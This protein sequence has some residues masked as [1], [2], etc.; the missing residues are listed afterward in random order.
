MK[1]EKEVRKAEFKKAVIKQLK[2]MIAPL[3]IL[4]IIAI[5]IIVVLFWKKEP[6]AE[7]FI[8]VR[9][10]EDGKS[11][12]V[13]E[14]DQLKLVMDGETTQFD[15]TVKSSG[16]VW[17][18]VPEGVDNDA[19]ALTLE[20]EKLKS[21]LLLTYST[22]NG[23]D[24]LYQNSTYSMERKTYQIDES[25]NAL[26]IHYTVGELEKEYIVPPIIS[27]ERMNAYLEKMDKNQQMMVKE[28]YKK[29]DI[30]NLGKKDNKEELLE[31]YPMLENEICYIIKPTVKGNIRTK[32]EQYFE[33]AGYTKQDYVEDKK[34]DLTQS[35]SNKPVFNLDMIYRLEGG[36]LVVEIPL[37][38][39]EYKKDYPVIKLCMLPYFGAGGV[40]D[41]GYILVPEGGGAII[42]F[43]NGNTAQNGYYANVYGW[44]DAIDRA[45]VVH[46]THTSFNVFGIAQGK[47]S[48]LCILEEGAPRASIQA[49][50]SGKLSSYNFA[51]VTHD[52]L[53]R[54]QYEVQDRYTGKMF[55]YEKELPDEMIRNRYRFVDSGDYVKMAES[56]HDYLAERTEGGL[57]LQQETV[58]PAVIEILCAADKV[59]QVMGVPVNRPLKLTTF[60]EA[61]S[62]LD[63]LNQNGIQNM[64]VKLT[65]WMNGGVN[66]KI[67]TDTKLVSALGSRKDL[68]DLISFAEG[69]GMDFYLDGNVSYA[70]DSKTSDGFM[71]FRDAARFVSDEKAELLPY[72]TITY[73]KKK[74]E[75]A[76]YLLRESVIKKAFR[77]LTKTAESYQANVS[78]QDIGMN[79]SSDFREDEPVS[80][81]QALED[82]VSLIKEL[83]SSGKKLMTN[84]GNDYAA[85]YSDLITNMEFSGARY[86]IINREVP[87]Y[88][89]AL[90]GYV[91]YTGESIN[92]AQDYEE[93]VLRC[94]EYG[95]G[96][97]FTV[98]Q[99]ASS[100][101]QN[102]YYSKYFG[103]DYEGWKDRIVEI[104]QRYNREL[105]HTFSQRMVN[106]IQINDKLMCTVYE[107]GTK[108]YVNYSYTDTEADGR[109]IPARDYAVVR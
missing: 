1:K 11:E 44:D 21:T 17:H 41:E 99:E 64:S 105:G 80:R 101:L 68:K 24:T 37:K 39:L 18:S 107:D 77:N 78:L 40:T 60:K 25:E 7:Q 43:N 14:N 58:A 32:M 109:T 70:H 48:F 106:H 52:I 50:I 46:D 102:T 94:A 72:S 13:I 73:G 23:V 76:Y 19:K 86:A 67:L 96:L 38:S 27:E 5:G 20:K 92:L 12:Y 34:N 104:Y 61:R 28:A 85:C 9:N 57:T 108:V 10:F 95:A 31:N 88:Q 6:E 16:K 51:N 62:I 3:I 97:S 84:F 49:D 93:E 26:T 83:K 36:D 8:E 103:T 15:L 69:A 33:E 71:V 79:L 47:D 65:G 22:I 56:Y 89:I 53:H 66:Q 29:Y 45:A 87:F 4:G 75:D 81:Q 82:Q 100:V 30:N 59:K 91:D 98:M 2:S 42:D 63:E 90:H 54:E 55:V 74:G 35:S